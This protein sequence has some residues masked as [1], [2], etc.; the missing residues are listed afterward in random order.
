M[1]DKELPVAEDDESAYILD[2]IKTIGWTTIAYDPDEYGIGFAYSVGLS[3]S[4]DHPE[5]VFVGLLASQAAQLISVIGKN[6]QDGR[7]FRDG[8]VAD[9]VV[10]G[11]PVA[12]RSVPAKYHR[13][14]KKVDWLYQDADVSLIQCFW[15]DQNQL[16]PW[17]DGC[18]EGCRETQELRKLI[19]PLGSTGDDQ[20]DEWLEAGVLQAVRLLPF[21][22]HS[23]VNT[24]Y[25]PSAGAAAKHSIDDRIGQAAQGQ[26]VEHYTGDQEYD[27][28]SRI[29]DRILIKA[30]GPTFSIEETIE[31]TKP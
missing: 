2:K 7:A 11:L 23:P 21:S 17:D 1:S 22:E 3:H 25:L 8:D 16:F 19:F 14:A 27:D 10:S 13:L 20:I 4:F 18:D 6:I 15:P 9:E 5:I 24:V 26:G 12:F 28:D 29:P 31:V 30:S